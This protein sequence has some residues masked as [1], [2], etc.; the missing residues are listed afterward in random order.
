MAAKGRELQK[1]AAGDLFQPAEDLFGGL[2]VVDQ[3]IEV[4]Q[5][6]LLFG[7][8][9]GP[10]TVETVGAQQGA[11]AGMGRLLAATRLGPAGTFDHQGAARLADAVQVTQQLAPHVFQIQVRKPLGIADTNQHDATVLQARRRQHLEQL[12]LLAGKAADRHG[13]AESAFCGLVE[14]GG[15]GEQLAV[16]GD[17]HGDGARGGQ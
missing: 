4:L 5:G 14:L 9:L 15:A 7:L 13:A 16:V 11:V 1:H 17:R 2:E 3:D 8:F 10:V 6:R 12:V